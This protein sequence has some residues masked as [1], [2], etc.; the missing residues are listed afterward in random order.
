MGEVE[1]M[2]KIFSNLRLKDSNVAT[3]FVPT[4]RKENRSKMLQKIDENEND[5]GK[6]RK[7]IDGR[8]GWYVEKYDL[9]DKYTRR[10]KTCKDIDE[11]SYSQFW[12]MCIP[13]RKEPKIKINHNMCLKIQGL[14]IQRLKPLT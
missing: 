10:D 8:D 9:V 2:Y 11:L 1:A 4:S 5:F 13:A 6:E 3:Q 7:K 14:K 12:K